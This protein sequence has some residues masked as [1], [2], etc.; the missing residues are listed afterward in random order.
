MISAGE[1]AVSGFGT[2]I[3]GVGTGHCLHAGFNESYLSNVDE[4]MVP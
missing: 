4:K 3:A 2:Q 1:S